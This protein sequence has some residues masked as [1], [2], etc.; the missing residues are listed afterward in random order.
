MESDSKAY[1]KRVAIASGV[2]LAIV[3]VVVIIALPKPKDSP[4]PVQLN[5]QGLKLQELEK[6]DENMTAAA[7]DVYYYNQNEYPANI[8]D[9]MQFQEP[10]NKQ[11]VQGGIDYLRNLTYIPSKDKQTYT[12]TYLS[13]NKQTISHSGD[14]NQQYSQ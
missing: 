9:V 13:V 6:A 5:A 12:F 2:I 7:L 3:L 1:F 11:I 8:E 14:Y 4:V 10:Q